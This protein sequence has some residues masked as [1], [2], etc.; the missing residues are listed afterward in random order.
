MQ[1]LSPE[2]VSI[3]GRPDTV[4]FIGSGVSVW[5][6]LPSW[7]QLI[8]NLVTRMESLNLSTDLIR[9]EIN[10]NDLLQAASYGL[11]KLTPQQRSEFLRNSCA[12]GQAQP[13][14]IHAI[15]MS[16]ENNCYITTNYDTLLETAIRE[17]RPGAA[18]DV[19]TPSQEWEVASL[20][21]ARASNFVFKP[22]G[23]IG[24][25]AK[26]VITREDY[27]VLKNE[28][29]NVF[30][31][32]KMLLT[33]RPVVYVGFGLRDPD[34]LL[35]KESIAS[36]FGGSPQDHYAIMPDVSDDEIDY[37]RRNY[38]IH[39]ISYETDE[40]DESPLGR[41]K[42]LLE[43]LTE[44]GV[45]IQADRSMETRVDV[46][47][48]TTA[49]ETLALAR[50]ARHLRTK[51]NPEAQRNVSEILPIKLVAGH[52]ADNSASIRRLEWPVAS[53][54]LTEFSGKCVVE[55]APGAGKTF[56]MESAL[57]ARAELLED[58][59]LDENSDLNCLPVPIYA[60]LS[61]YAGSIQQNLEASLPNDLSFDELYSAGRLAIF[62][63]AFNEIPS[64]YLESG[65]AAEDIA[66]LL[67]N[68]GE[69]TII[70]TTRFGSEIESLDLPV[71]RLDM[72]D[73]NYVLNSL[74]EFMGS[75]SFSKAVISVFQ[76][77]LFFQQYRAGVIV[78]SE[79]FNVHDVY[80]Q[81]ISYYTQKASEEMGVYVPLDQS[82]SFVGY[83][84]VDAG[85]LSL[86]I[87]DL[88]SQMRRALPPDVDPTRLVSWLLKQDLLVPLPNKRV[89]FSHH[90]LPE[91]FA[92]HRLG[93]MFTSDSSAPEACFG[94]KRWDQ[95]ILLTLGFLSDYDAGKLLD[96][97]FEV[98]TRMGLRSLN[99]VETNSSDW[100]NYGL[101]IVYDRLAIQRNFELSM[102]LDF[103]LR[104]LSLD[105]SALPILWSLAEQ[106]DSL[107]GVAAAKIWVIGTSADRETLI[108]HI[109]E[110][111]DF[112][113][114]N[115]F[116]ENV[117][118]SMTDA[119]VLRCFIEA[120]KIVVSP[121]LLAEDTDAFAAV[122]SAV[123]TLL[124]RVPFETIL[125]SLSQLPS[126]S[127]LLEQIVLHKCYDDHSPAALRY[128]TEAVIRD[129][130]R[131]VFALH[132]QLMHA[133]LD[134]A[135]VAVVRDSDVLPRLIDELYSNKWAVSLIQQLAALDRSLASLID[136]YCDKDDRAIRVIWRYLLGDQSAFMGGL[137]EMMHTCF[138][139]TPKARFLLE[140]LDLDWRG[141][142]EILV[143]LFFNEDTELSL[144]VAQTVS[145]HSALGNSTLQRQRV[146]ELASFIERITPRLIMRPEGTPEALWLLAHLVD[147][148]NLEEL[149]RLVSGGSVSQRRVIAHGVLSQLSSFSLNQLPPETIE[150]LIHDLGQDA[151]RWPFSNLL[152]S[153][154]ETVI[155]EKLL[156]LLLEDISPPIRGE[157]LEI[158]KTAGARHGRRY[159]DESG[160]LLI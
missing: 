93:A 125:E 34:F 107:G 36:E 54:A 116:A 123:G 3:A 108:R 100:M 159:V 73:Q 103:E 121:E 84:M 27:S 149:T 35:L 95:A 67:E 118:A 45:R 150:W 51:Y 112:N 101:R 146:P 4:V 56:M 63:D 2:L 26:I 74:N 88:H 50:H 120:N 98:D 133:D 60:S 134:A 119:D 139:W 75:S 81:L 136:D 55:G 117:V 148:E 86:G 82:L 7:Y 92:A 58:L 90:S 31:T 155:T 62:L 128:T 9:R 110:R 24:D 76:R 68:A 64:H 78:P 72:I 158:L 44:V 111:D 38:G 156:P 137:S 19:I 143:R 89:M 17:Q 160:E 106:G 130:P 28:R 53:L 71:V 79:I 140:A 14:E 127:P 5:A 109:S 12:V 135:E 94:K 104:Q 66:S 65:R 29:K 142:E 6:G 131:A 153:A 59:C 122:Q 80:S 20:Q 16:W 37:W 129:A 105:A 97:I 39:I 151:R 33:S 138:K 11:D 85:D 157:L 83:Q 48:A 126:A 47:H 124:G 46:V 23:D 70:I 87:T 25:T 22:H 69:N 147:E 1:N 32:Y 102:S 52:S 115:R 30:N 21:Q 114:L 61:Q 18:F 144:S 41:H 42:P 145:R 43:L 91:Y 141:Y 154:N 96:R 15:L 49:T 8:D 13:S 132:L 40:N 10:N 113:Y 77:P 152:S 99:Y 57:R